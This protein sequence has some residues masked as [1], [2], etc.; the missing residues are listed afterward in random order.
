MAQIPQVAAQHEAWTPLRGR[1]RTLPSRLWPESGAVSPI[2][3]VDGLRALAVLL[4]LL[5]HAWVHIPWV[6]QA[7]GG[8]EYQDPVDYGRTGVQL[9]FVLSGFL[10]FQPYAKWLFGLQP[11]PSALLFYKRRALRVGPAYWVNLAALLLLQP[12]SLAALGSALAHVLFLSNVFFYSTIDRFNIVFWTMA[13]EVQFY[14][15]LPAIAWLMHR[16]TRTLRPLTAIVVVVLGLSLVSAVAA[17]LEKRYGQLPYVSS[18]L[19]TRSGLP[20]WIGV[21]ADGIVCGTL[22]VYLRQVARLDSRQRLLLGRWGDAL[23]AGGLAFGLVTVFIPALHAVPYK[24]Q[25]FGLIYGA[26]VF[27]VL[28]GRPLLRTP[29]ESRLLRFI[30]LISYSL[31]LWHYMVLV[32]IEPHLSGIAD[33]PLRTAAGFGLDVL[34]AVPLAYLSFQLTERPF[35]AARKHAHERTE[36]GT[37]P[38]RASD[39]AQGAVSRPA[40][41]SVGLS[42]SQRAPLTATGAAGQVE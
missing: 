19:I 23:F 5:L 30:G 29:F 2:P 16:V 35:F 18:W 41:G 7:L 4:V 1:W 8:R 36:A 32:L 40:R 20:F 10:L 12:L 39:Q 24:N 31:Y 15:L 38:S 9:F 27:G 33:I 3:A 21:F 6:Q 42:A 26:M 34:F 13:V 25:L 11:R 37:L 14:V 22:Y 17:T 28:F